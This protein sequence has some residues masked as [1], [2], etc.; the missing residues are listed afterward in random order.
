MPSLLITTTI[1]CL[2][3]LHQT[4]AS[5]GVVD[6]DELLQPNLAQQLLAPDGPERPY[7]PW[8]HKPY[9][10]T[11][12]RLQT[13]GQKYCVYTSNTTGP[14]G[15]SFIFPPSS[16]RL[17]TQHLDDNPLDSFLTQDEAEDLFLGDGPPWKIVD[18]PG[19]DKGVVAT[20]KIK[21]YET[22]MMDQ[23]AVVVDME[24]EKAL[25][26]RENQR[27]L[28][29]AVD[30]LLVPGMIR[31]MSDKHEGR[32]DDVAEEKEEEEEGM[33]EEHIMKTNAFGGTIA[34]VSSRALYPVIS[35]INHACNPNSFVL[36]SRAGVSMA[37]K[38][39]RDIQPGEEITI[40]YL[41]LG[42]PFTQR[43]HLIKRWGFTCTC[44]LCSRPDRERQASDL[45]RT[46]IAQAEEKIVELANEGK[47]DEAIKLAEECVGMI[48]DEDIYPM[49][50]DSY[51]MLAMLYLEK[52]D[53]AKAE[54]YG[55]KAL[56][57]LGNLGFLGVG[58]EREAWNFQ[59]LLK[60]ME[61]LGATGSGWRKGKGKRSE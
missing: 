45:R 36:F 19:K 4:H 57:L 1:L 31:D 29:I 42:T 59:M 28:K 27:L 46:M 53:H 58:E 2:F 49:L 26:Q 20:R 44:D 38:A 47:A 21:Q 11:S 55:Q 35:R 24:A 52:A 60:N 56:D 9:C 34:D 12:K 54:E 14:H 13:L 30:R 23:A 5:V 25:S 41:L 43:Q 37:I 51:T 50:T 7:A 8:S 16:A 3:T 22:F 17:A 6:I 40:S 61:G 10:T 48:R 39:Y 33:L 32:S 15:L 18:I